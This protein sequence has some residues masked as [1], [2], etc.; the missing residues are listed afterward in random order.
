M[1]SNWIQR[2]SESFVIAL[3]SAVSKKLFFVHQFVYSNEGTGV[4]S[5]EA[6]GKKTKKQ[7]V[8]QR[9]QSQRGIIEIGDPG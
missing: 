6:I 4:P 3:Q 5:D 8:N 7:S 2:Y 1:G 9:G